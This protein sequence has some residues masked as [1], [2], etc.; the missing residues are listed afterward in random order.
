MKLGRWQCDVC[1]AIY[2]DTGD[3]ECPHCGSTERS[4][5]EELDEE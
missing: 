4:E 5:Y 1:G 3:L 2:E